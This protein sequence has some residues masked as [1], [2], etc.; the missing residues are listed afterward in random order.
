MESE[1]GIRM[2]YGGKGFRLL[3]VFA[4]AE[5]DYS[6]WVEECVPDG[7]TLQMLLFALAFGLGKKDPFFKNKHKTPGEVVLYEYLGSAATLIKYEKK[8]KKYLHK[9]NAE[10][11]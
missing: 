8:S 1:E 3:G 11:N 7:R 5:Q 6:L 4:K 10:Q 9:I 2:N